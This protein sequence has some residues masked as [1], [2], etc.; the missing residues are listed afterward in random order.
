[1]PSVSIAHDVA[2]HTGGASVP[3][4]PKLVRAVCEDAAEWECPRGAKLTLEG[5]ALD[6]V[7]QVRFVGQAG[8]GDD[9]S[10]RPSTND[11]HRVELRVPASARSGPM[12]VVSVHGT[13][14][15]SQRRLRV[16]PFVAMPGGTSALRSA[17]ATGVFPIAGRHSYGTSVNRF[18]GGRGHGGQDVFADCGTP[19]VAVSDATVQHVGSQARAG[20]YVVL[21]REDGESFAYM[22]MQRPAAARKGDILAAGQAVG[23]VGDT[24]RASGCHLHF[25]QWT[26]PGWYEGGKA[27]DPIGL[28]RTL[29]R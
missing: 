22:H 1:M 4:E 19:L 16:R 29:D 25:E 10:V 24:G 14:V 17:E 7:R 13:R 27:V 8:P 2:G 28:L 20:N 6:Q 11:A 5:E 12:A 3:D 18:G 26:A 15:L 9:R 23:R 21:Q